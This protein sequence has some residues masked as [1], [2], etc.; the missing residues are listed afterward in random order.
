M[1]E[2]TRAPNPDSNAAICWRGSEDEW[3]AKPPYPGP[4][5]MC[6][7]CRA[8]LRTYCSGGAAQV[9]ATFTPARWAAVHPR[10]VQ[11]VCADRGTVRQY[12][13][14]LCDAC[15]RGMRGIADVG[16]VLVRVEG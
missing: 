1:A 14:L 4:G 13:E 2:I 15:A 3:R 10:A 16:V 7:R 8:T 6:G 9:E 11:V 12:T 5:P